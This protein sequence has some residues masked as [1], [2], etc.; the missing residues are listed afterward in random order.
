MA[1]AHVAYPREV[2]ERVRNNRAVGRH[3]LGRI[4]HTSRDNGVLRGDCLCVFLGLF[5]AD[6]T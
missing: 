3:I 5:A 6:R 4:P 1:L 2:Q